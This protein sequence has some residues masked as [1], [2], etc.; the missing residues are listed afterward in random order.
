MRALAMVLLFA[1]T[2]YAVLDCARTPSEQLPARMPKTMW[3]LIILLFTGVGPIAWIISSRVKAAEERGGVVE[4]SVWSSSEPPAIRLPERRRN[5][6][7]S[8]IAPDDDPEFLRKLDADL[9]RQRAQKEKKNNMTEEG[10]QIEQQEDNCSKSKE[11]NSHEDGTE[12]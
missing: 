11:Q 3:I 6:P 8:P 2:L 7:R 5:E 1:L 4:R 10:S 12:H 9:Q